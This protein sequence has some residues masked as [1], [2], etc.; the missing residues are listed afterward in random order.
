MV[1]SAKAGPLRWRAAGWLDV[2]LPEVRGRDR[3]LRAVHGP[4]HPLPGTRGLLTNGLVFDFD[5]CA[6]G[7]MYAL[8]G[9]QSRPPAL[10]AAVDAL[11]AEGAVVYDVGAN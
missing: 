8:I 6:D 2:R 3:L 9:L 7:S 4:V 11:A 1:A 5:G 10:A